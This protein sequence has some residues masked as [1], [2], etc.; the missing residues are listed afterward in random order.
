MI[1]PSLRCPV[2]RARPKCRLKQPRWLKVLRVTSTRRRRD[3]SSVIP[4]VEKLNV[5]NPALAAPPMRQRRPRLEQHRMGGD[6]GDL[7]GAEPGR[8]RLV[9]HFLTT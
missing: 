6:W 7:D 4:K 1:F 3:Q 9:R 8:R 2:A 5:S